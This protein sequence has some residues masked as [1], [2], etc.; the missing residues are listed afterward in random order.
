LLSNA[1]KNYTPV[2]DLFSLLGE[3]LS[4]E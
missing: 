1:L 2:R 3:R 4:E